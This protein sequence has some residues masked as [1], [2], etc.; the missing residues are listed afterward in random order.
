MEV[1]LRLARSADEPALRELDD[2]ARAGDADRIALLREAVANGRCLVAEDD[3][4][5]GY[6]VTA[7]AHFF[8]RDFVELIVVHDAVRRRGVGRALLRAAVDRAGT[9][10]VFS[11]TNAS[12]EAMKSLFAAEGWTLSGQLDGLDE[13]DP[14][15][16]YFIDQ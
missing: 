8:A 12:N 1:Q 11:S 14:E 2:A 3:R 4:I 13:G 15:I 10:R 9:S 5:I 7:P 6:A 16:V